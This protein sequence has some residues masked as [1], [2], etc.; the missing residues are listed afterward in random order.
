MPMETMQAR[1]ERHGLTKAAFIDSVNFKSKHKVPP[2]YS[3]ALP[4]HAKGGR[5]R[6]P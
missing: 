1:I 6:G 5:E 2:S 3:R 4:I